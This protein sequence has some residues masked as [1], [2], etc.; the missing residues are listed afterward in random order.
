MKA[1]FQL[2]YPYLSEHYGNIRTHADLT[3]AKI[4]VRREYIESSD[5]RVSLRDTPL[6]DFAEASQTICTFVVLLEAFK[7]HVL[8][9]NC[10]CEGI[11]FFRSVSGMTSVQLIIAG[12]RLPNESDT[13]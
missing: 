7:P 1:I 9:N 13:K 12:T 4:I 6:V 10:D 3:S 8:A 5:K 11:F 2:I